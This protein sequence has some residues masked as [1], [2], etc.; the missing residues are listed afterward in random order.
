MLHRYARMAQ[1]WGMH[2]H[3]PNWCWINQPGKYGLCGTLLLWIT[4]SRVLGVLEPL[5]SYKFR[6]VKIEM[7]RHQAWSVW[8]T[9]FFFPGLAGVRH[10]ITAT[11]AA[12][13]G[14]CWTSPGQP[15]HV[16]CCTILADGSL[17][18]RLGRQSFSYV[19]NCKEAKSEASLPN[20]K[21][22]PI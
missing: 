1:T 5:K 12:S 19:A 18:P 3:N 4:G 7:S 14:W 21:D 2:L 9:L 15:C 6:P 10:R 16:T 11:I 20:L 8:T 13:K 17:R 22:D